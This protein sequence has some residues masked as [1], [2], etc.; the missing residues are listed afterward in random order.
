MIN[1]IIAHT[2]VKIHFNVR[3]RVEGRGLLSRRS[4]YTVSRSTLTSSFLL[5]T[6]ALER[7][8]SLSVTELTLTVSPASLR[9]MVITV[10]S[11]S[12]SLSAITTE[13]RSF[14]TFVKFV[15]A[16]VSVVALVAFRLTLQLAISES[17]ATL[18]IAMPS[19]LASR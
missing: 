7:M 2:I 9:S 18:A 3:M 14:V 15:V 4:T 6:S 13:S 16:L 1:T 11:F 19:A 5:L 17:K 10:T 12:V 8:R